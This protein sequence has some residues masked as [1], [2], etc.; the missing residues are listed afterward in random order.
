MDLAWRGLFNSDAHRVRPAN[1]SRLVA[2]GRSFALSECGVACVPFAGSWPRSLCL[3]CAAIG[4]TQEL[5][6]IPSQPSRELMV[7]VLEGLQRL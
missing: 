7:R 5:M 4:D 6:P 1:A 2:Q 3:A